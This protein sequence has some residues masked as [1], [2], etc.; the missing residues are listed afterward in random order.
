M[1]GNGIRVTRCVV[2][3]Y[4]EGR[5]VQTVRLV[6]LLETFPG[7][8]SHVWG[9][10]NTHTPTQEWH[11]Q[12]AYSKPGHFLSKV[13]YGLN[14]V[15]STTFHHINYPICQQKFFSVG[16]AVH[17]LTRNFTKQSLRPQLSSISHGYLLESCLATAEGNWTHLVTEAF[18][19]LLFTF[20]FLAP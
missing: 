17:I 19:D 6:L 20:P 18:S 16:H 10:I 14:L 1:E 2:T 8:L 13:Y 11:Q 7:R 5:D 15:V 3:R 12:F 4:N 9:L